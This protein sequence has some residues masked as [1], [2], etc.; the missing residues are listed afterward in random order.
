MSKRPYAL[1]VHRSNVEFVQW[2]D[3]ISDQ[4]FYWIRDTDQVYRVSDEEGMVGP[5]FTVGR[6]NQEAGMPD[7]FDVKTALEQYLAR[8]SDAS[9]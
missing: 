8:G 6:D 1:V 2:R 5:V 7:E 3:A 4:V 9:Q